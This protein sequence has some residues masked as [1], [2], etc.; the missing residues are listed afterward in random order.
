[1]SCGTFYVNKLLLEVSGLERKPRIMER[2]WVGGIAR[3]IFERT[4]VKSIFGASF[5]QQYEAGDGRRQPEGRSGTLLSSQE[6]DEG[7]VLGGS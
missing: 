2:V 7:R 1:M 4:A 6:E 3:L 5:G